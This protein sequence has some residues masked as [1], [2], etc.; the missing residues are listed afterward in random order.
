MTL[1]LGSNRDVDIAAQFAA[2]TGGWV[3]VNGFSGYEPYHYDRLRHGSRVTDPVIFSPFRA[4]GDLHVV[5]AENDS[6]QVRLVEQQAGVSRVAAAGGWRQY[7]LP[8]Q[9]RLPPSLP[10]GEKRAIAS[11]TVSC[12]SDLVPL[13]T[14]GD[15]TN[16]WQCGPQR[17]G[18]ELTAD[19]G[20]PATVGEVIPA[21]GRF[22][23]DFPRHLRIETSIDGRTWEPGW[24]GGVLAEL[25]EAEFSDPKANAIVLSFPPRPAR[26]VRLRLMNG[27]D[28]WYWSIAELEVW[29]GARAH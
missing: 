24:D 3:S 19:L 17:P 7:R 22:P 10:A 5:V 16:R 23:T 12:S 28:T 27:D 2:V 8:R 18:Q 11:V 26:Y 20:T 14:D 21:L 4:R 25:I 1:P 6:S 13:V 9:G 29:S 15:Y